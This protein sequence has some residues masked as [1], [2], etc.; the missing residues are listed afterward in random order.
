[1]IQ[2]TTVLQIT[3]SDIISY[4]S[5]TLKSVGDFQDHL[6]KPNCSGLDFYIA[7]QAEDR[8]N[9]YWITWK[10]KL[11]KKA[12]KLDLKGSLALRAI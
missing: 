11:R 4:N 10:T 7:W 2:E 6:L 12:L 3:F 8:F 1:M 5:I 9:K